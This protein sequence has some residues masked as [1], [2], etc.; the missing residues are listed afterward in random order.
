MAVSHTDTTVLDSLTYEDFKN[1]LK[2]HIRKKW[3]IINNSQTKKLNQLKTITFRWNNHNLN[4][5]DE[6]T[7]NR[8]RIVHTRL[9][10]GFLMSKKEPPSCEAGSLWPTTHGQT[11]PDRIPSIY[12]QE[13]MDLKFTETLDS[14]LG[15]NP[16][17]NK[18][19][20]FFVTSNN[21]IDNI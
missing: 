16:D 1:S 10:H 11:Y 4:R 8:L 12:K 20:L 3:H 7:I 13:P 15:P 2:T 6:T 14:T 21:L 5:K 9:T 17:Q 18:K 19:I